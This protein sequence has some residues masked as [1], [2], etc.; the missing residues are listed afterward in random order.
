MITGGTNMNH[1][2]KML[3][4]FLFG[5]F[6]FA[7]TQPAVQ[8]A[9]ATPSEPQ[10]KMNLNVKIEQPEL[11]WMCSFLNKDG[12]IGK[13]EMIQVEWSIGA[14]PKDSKVQILIPKGKTEGNIAISTIKGDFVSFKVSVYGKDK[15]HFA[16]MGMQVK[17]NGQTETI[18]ITPPEII[19]PVLNWSN[20][21]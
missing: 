4:V 6:T 12:D 15:T 17:N 21:K 14:L 9:P 7:A 11:F 1:E 19:E 20:Q 8:A 5:I 3:L 18:T 13:P 10:T 16:S 2:S